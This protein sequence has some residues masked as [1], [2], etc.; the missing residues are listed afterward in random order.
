MLSTM[1]IGN[2]ISRL[3]IGPLV[4]AWKWD[5]TKVY[6]VSQLVCAITIASFPIVVNGVQM[7]IQGF[8]FSLTFGCQCLLFGNFALPNGG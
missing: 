5:V 3:V 2:L 8:L 7:I 6:A 1:G 4:T